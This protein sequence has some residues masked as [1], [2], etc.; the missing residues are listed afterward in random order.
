MFIVF[1]ILAGAV[2][3]TIIHLTVGHRN[4]R[5]LL[6]SG[7]IGT[8]VAAVIYAALTWA[9]LGQD[10]IWMWVASIGGSVVL[11]LLATVIVTSTRV[12]ADARARTAAGIR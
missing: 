11:T 2:A 8:V 10:S 6:L 1:A 4:V 9:G 12:A 5:G 3:G 7:A